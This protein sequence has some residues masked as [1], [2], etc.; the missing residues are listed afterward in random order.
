[1]TSRSWVKLWCKQWLEGTLKDED[2]AIRGVWAGFMALAGSGQ[3]GDSGEIKI[4]NGIG[5][6][7]KQLCEILNIKK[8]LLKKAK[9]RFVDSQ[10]IEISPKGAIS[11]VNWSKYQSEY[12]R[13]RPYRKH[14]AGEELEENQPF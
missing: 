10:R 3:Y 13:Q 14:K 1:M 2:I 12:G 5:F 6:T 7:D 8:H 11:I 9:L 4:Q